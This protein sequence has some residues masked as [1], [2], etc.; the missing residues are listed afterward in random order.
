MAAE[1][2]GTGVIVAAAGALRK[3][4]QPD[5][6]DGKHLSVSK[7][8]TNVVIRSRFRRPLKDAIILLDGRTDI[9]E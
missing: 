6:K 7:R 4:A 5:V 2:S 8:N 1:H 9:I 3:G